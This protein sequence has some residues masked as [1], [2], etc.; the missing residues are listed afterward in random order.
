MLEKDRGDESQ[1]TN[2]AD[3]KPVRLILVSSTEKILSMSL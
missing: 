1:C 2:S 3:A